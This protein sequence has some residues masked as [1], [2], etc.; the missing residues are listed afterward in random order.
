LLCSPSL[1]IFPLLHTMAHTLV[2]PKKYFFYPIGNT[3]AVSLV[4]DLSPEEDAKILLLGCGDPR[5]ILY[6]TYASGADSATCRLSLCCALMFHLIA[7]AVQHRERWTSLAVILSRLFWVC[8]ALSEAS[9]GATD[10]VN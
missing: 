2:W 4:Q 6:T 1:H 10:L 8:F 3:A 5:N 7:L 9:G